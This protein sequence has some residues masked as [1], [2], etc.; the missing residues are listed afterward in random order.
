M[1]YVI[2]DYGHCYNGHWIR[3]DTDL[4]TNDCFV[5]FDNG[6]RMMP[7]DPAFKT[8]EDFLHYYGNTGTEWFERCYRKAGQPVPLDID[9]AQGAWDLLEQYAQEATV[10]SVSHERG[11]E[12]MAKAKAKADTGLD[13]TGVPADG[14]KARQVADRKVVKIKMLAEYDAD[15]HGKVAKQVRGTLVALK[16]LGADKNAVDKQELLIKMAEHVS[17]VQSMAKI[18]QHYRAKMV[19]LGFVEITE[20]AKTPTEKIA[21]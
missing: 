2:T 3:F 1:T 19:R 10:V 12:V 14:K 21:A 17:S 7:G 13:Q 15:K 6:V 18:F 9:I 8:I 20:E 11:E 5:D 4:C 16:E